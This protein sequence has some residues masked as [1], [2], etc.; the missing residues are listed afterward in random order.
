MEAFREMLKGWVGKS[1]LVLVTVPFA[2]VGIESYFAGGGKVVAAKVNGTEILQPE[3]DQA[4][5]AQRQKMLAEMGAKANPA[6]I[7]LVR[8]RKEVLD[9]MISRELLT[10][11]S[12]KDGYLISDAMVYR[13]IREVPAFQENGAFS[14]TRYEQVLQQN[15][16]NPATY[17]ATAK[18]EMAY[19]ML[20]TGMGQ[21]GF[22]STPELDR[23]SALD[24]QKRDVHITIIPAARYM[25]DITVSE[26][27][28]GKFY[29]ANPKRFT[30]QETV[31]LD[32]IVLKREDFL[33]Q[34]T[35]TDDDLQARYQEKV[36]A[37]AANEQRDAQHILITV[38]AKTP[39]AA[40]LKKIQDIAKRAQAGEDFGKL[41]KE[42]SQDPGSVANG[43]ELGFTGRGQLAPEF[44]KA[45]FSLKEGEISAPVKTQ[46]GYH[47]IKLNKIQQVETPSFAALKPVLE[48]EAK[49]AK[50]E[51]LFSEQADKIDTAAYE[52]SDLK[53]LAAKFNL[54][55]ASTE[56]FMRKGG[57]GVAAE[58]KVIDTAFSEDLLKDGKNSG[59]IQLADG[60]TAW[61]HVK[62]HAPAAL[63][64]L[65]D[66]RSDV[67]NQLILD[68]AEAKAK[69]VAASVTAA[70]AGGAS[71]AD[72][73]EREKLSWKDFP[74]AT[75]QA[76][77]QT[78]EILRV[79]Y[80]L[81]RPAAGKVSAD[82][83]PVA[84]AY[85][86][87]AVSKVTDGVAASGAEVA[88][89]RN[90]LSENRSQQEFQDYISALREINKVVV[91]A[92]NKS[93][94]DE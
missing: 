36:K 84:L 27:E 76:Q 9:G 12:K 24:S 75:R 43:G 94:T 10:Q 48:K 77:T 28:I 26:D 35:P 50:A 80:R 83:F 72:V 42:F 71:L 32:Y 57:T 17:P 39:D 87:V 73:A 20:I 1:L 93:K 91:I 67:R 41:A 37:N 29:Q 4:V 30:S 5:D 70:L 45:L 92:Q 49:T 52:A 74:E 34:A 15:G 2:I 62:N 7:D 61:L 58:R 66:I 89:M 47:L 82:S 23:L 78:P 19:S 16:K 14:Q 63:K 54:K 40:A 31:A 90:V 21:S 22:I 55:I 68:K 88:Q 38:D 79:A 65:V 64:P 44:D 53:D 85:I 81:P 33:A 11:Q 69:S 18:Q 3:V 86:V 51:Q 59:S 60:S 25:G 6:A 13:L 56:P 46:Y 8:I